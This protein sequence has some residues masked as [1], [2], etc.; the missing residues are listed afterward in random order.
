MLNFIENPKLVAEMGAKSRRLAEQRYNVHT[1]NR[2]I[3][4][5]MEL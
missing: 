2:D 5:R 3:I 1:I 4:S